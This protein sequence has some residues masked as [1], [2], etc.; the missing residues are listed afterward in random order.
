MA[1]DRFGF[2]EHHGFV[3]SSSGSTHPASLA[4]TFL[5]RFASR[6]GLVTFRQTFVRRYHCLAAV[7]FA[8]QVR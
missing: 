5:S 2:L 4:N 1:R 7:R 8:A 6:A 3:K